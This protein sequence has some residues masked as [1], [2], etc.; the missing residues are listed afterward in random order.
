MKPY[1]KDAYKERKQAERDEAYRP[2]DITAERA[3]SSGEIYAKYLN[4][5]ARYNRYSVN[6]ALLIAAQMPK[7]TKLAT[8]EEWQENK[9]QIRA[10]A[11]AINLLE[12]GREY[13]REDCSVGAAFNV[14]KGFDNSQTFAVPQ[15][16][17]THR[18]QRLMMKAFINNLPCKP[19][20]SDAQVS[21]NAATI[22]KPKANTIYIRYGLNLEDMF[23][24]PA[25]ELAVALLDKDGA[26]SRTVCEFQAWSEAYMVFARNHIVPD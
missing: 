1:D 15:K 6:T 12:P 22:Y 3:A 26:F 8:F 24:A 10:G 14:K 5:Q 13:Q 7:A 2:A 11:N 21:A 20:I 19:E 4:V 16:T 23:R 25:R 9:V 18:D 17:E